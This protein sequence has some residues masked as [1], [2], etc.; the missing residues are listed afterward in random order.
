MWS[1][2]LTHLRQHSIKIREV[3]YQNT[4]VS[5]H[6]EGPEE[7]RKVIDLLY[8]KYWEYHTYQL[9]EEK[10]LKVVPRVTLQGVTEKEIIE[11]LQAGGFHLIS[12]SRMSRKQNGE[13]T[14]IP[15][16]MVQ[17]PKDAK[18]VFEVWSVCHFRI[19]VESLKSRAN[20]GQCHN[21]QKFDQAQNR[22]QTAPKCVVSHHYRDCTRER[23]TPV[24]CANC[25][26]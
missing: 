9:M 16:V 5:I 10:S 22:C 21:Y 13:K 17:Y 8:A 25:N 18:K 20:E 3:K 6:P 15:L 12:A 7:Y 1:T 24:K 2:F 11:H 23:R 19:T 26:G 4:G 14:P